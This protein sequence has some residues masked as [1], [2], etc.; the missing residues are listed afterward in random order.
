MVAIEHAISIVLRRLKSK[1]YLLSCWD[2]S[3]QVETFSLFFC[4][5]VSRRCGILQIDYINV[6][7]LFAMTMIYFRLN[8]FSLNCS[9]LSN[10]FS[11]FSLPCE[12]FKTAIMSLTQSPR[13]PFYDGQ[14]HPA[15]SG[16]TFQTLNPSNATP[17]TDIHIASQAD[18][19]AAIASADRAFKSWSQTPYIARARILQRA[20]AL[21]REKNDDIA[22]VESLDSG[23]AYTETSTVDVVSGADVLEYYANLVGG[24]GLEGETTQ[25][26]EDASVFTKKAPLGVCGGIGAWNYPIQM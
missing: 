9:P 15:T 11:H 12:T 19:D 7:P 2:L 13:Q 5:M 17:L 23:K 21:L 3:P 8:F 16:K 10:S 25:L 4:V 20:A 22:R 26:R 14:I 18:V 1:A 6:S 24:G